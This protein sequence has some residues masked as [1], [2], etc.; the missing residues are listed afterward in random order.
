MKP[1]QYFHY[2]S[3]LLIMGNLLAACCISEDNSKEARIIINPLGNHSINETFEINGTTSLGVDEKLRYIISRKDVAVPVPCPTGSICTPMY[4]FGAENISSGDIPIKSDG[5]MG[6]SWSFFLNTTGY[7][8]Y[9]Y[10]HFKFILNVTSQNVTFHN[11][12]EL[13]LLS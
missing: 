2:F 12:T 7:E 3:F 13:T 8:Y 4:M 6:Q 10:K 5:R 9:H 1:N 11:S